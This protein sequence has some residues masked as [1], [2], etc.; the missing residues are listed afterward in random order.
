MVKNKKVIDRKKQQKLHLDFGCG[1][2]VGLH[3]SGLDN[4]DIL[5]D[6][7]IMDFGFAFGV[8]SRFVIN[9]IDESDSFGFVLQPEL[10]Y[11]NTKYDLSMKNY[12][13][14]T[15]EFSSLSVPLLFGFQGEEKP[16]K[17]RAAVGPVFQLLLDQKVEVENNT[18]KTDFKNMIGL[19]IDL[20]SDWGRITVDLGLNI[21]L[22]DFEGDAGFIEGLGY[23]TRGEFV[24]IEDMNQYMLMIT[25]GYK[26]F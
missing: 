12:D 4:S 20:G 22:T 1:P 18:E 23:H 17:L 14:A 10:L 9:R 26:F 15:L 8:F 24:E 3:V 25:L 7:A 5:E 11:Y 6:Y 13:N 2:M 21:G 19:K 16:L